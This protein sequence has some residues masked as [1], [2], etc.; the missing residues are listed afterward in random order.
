[1]SAQLF[2]VS[3]DERDWFTTR[4]KCWR[5]KMTISR[6]SEKHKLLNMSATARVRT[7]HGGH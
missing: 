1:M 7:K 2:F 6:L 5:K 4:E 3:N